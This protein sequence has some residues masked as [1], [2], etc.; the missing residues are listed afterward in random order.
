M[1]I[2]NYYKNKIQEFIAYIKHNRRFWNIRLLVF[3]DRGRI[4]LKIGYDYGYNCWDTI[5]PKKRPY[6]YT[7]F[8]PFL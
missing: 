1:E 6:Y 8:K 2:L 5:W 3:K 4:H 7:L